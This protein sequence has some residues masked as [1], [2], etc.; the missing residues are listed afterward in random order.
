MG[1]NTRSVDNVLHLQYELS[2][3]RQAIVE[4]TQRIMLSNAVLYSPIAKAIMSDSKEMFDAAFE[5]ISDTRCEVMYWWMVSFGAMVMERVDHAL[6]VLHTDE[7]DGN[8]MNT[9]EYLTENVMPKHT[10]DY[11]FSLLNRD[12]HWC[13]FA[14][15]ACIMMGKAFQGTVEIGFV[16]MPRISQTPL[17][18][19]EIEMYERVAKIYAQQ[20]WEARMQKVWPNP[21]E[22]EGE[23]EDE[24]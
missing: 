6:M 8:V 22:D 12:G 1:L 17:T 20:H 9:Y 2:D 16:S 13:L 21:C 7:V 11:K 18:K 4:H 5:G 23:D 10:D 19:I 3:N 24:D 15:T 14:Q